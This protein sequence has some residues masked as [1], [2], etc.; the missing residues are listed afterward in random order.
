VSAVREEHERD[1]V[2]YKAGKRMVETADTKKAN[3]VDD[4]VA[5]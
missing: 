3:V 2:W 4:G 5:P 1:S